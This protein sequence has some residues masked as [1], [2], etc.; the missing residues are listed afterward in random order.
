MPL[1]VY[2]LRLPLW[3]KSLTQKVVTK[4]HLVRVDRE[5]RQRRTLLTIAGVVFGIIILVL[6]YGLLDEFVLK[7]N[8]AVAKVNNERISLREF[9]SQVQFHSLADDPGIPAAL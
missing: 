4:K 5:R 3:L 7:Q 9:Q 8:R 2:E 1:I 6:A